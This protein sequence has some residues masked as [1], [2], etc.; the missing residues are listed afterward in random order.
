LLQVGKA[1]LS[2]SRLYLAGV[3][4]SSSKQLAVAALSR[5]AEIMSVCQVSTTGCRSTLWSAQGGPGG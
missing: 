5:A 2:L 4:E 1:Y 3:E